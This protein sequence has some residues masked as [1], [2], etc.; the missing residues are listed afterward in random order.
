MIKKIIICAFFITIS[1]SYSLAANP[2]W[3]GKGRIAVSCDGN[4]HDQDDWSA[5][6]MSLALIAAMGVQDKLAIYVFSDHVWG[7]NKRSCV[8]GLNHYQHMKKSALEGAEL[9]GF[10]KSRFICAVDNPEYAYEKMKE[11]I[12]CSSE[13]N[14]LII[15][16]AGPMQVVGEAVNR[17]DSDKL[18]YVTII[19]HSSWN[20][21]HGKEHNGWTLNKIGEKFGKQLKIV[22]ILD[23]NGRKG[24]IEGLQADTYHFD[25]LKSEALRNNPAYQ[26]GAIEWLYGRLQDGSLK[27]GKKMDVSDAGMFVFLFTG[28][29]KNS[30]QSLEKILKNPCA[31]N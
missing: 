18:K 17:A 15:V 24:E 2:L 21:D 6:P 5:T 1:A 31:R 16:A 9:F 26:K 23:Q 29:E 14:P 7:S 4:D 25:W 13:E 3:Q 28:E 12:N 19:S 30:P 22:Q 8:S 20:N 27:G 10:D 11:Q